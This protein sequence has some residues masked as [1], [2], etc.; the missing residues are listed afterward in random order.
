MFFV[1]FLIGFSADFQVGRDTNFV[2][3]VIASYRIPFSDLVFYKRDTFY[4][5]EY[6]VSLALK[7]DRYQMGGKSKKNKI[8]V[9]DYNETK[10]ENL[11]HSDSIKVEVPEGEVEVILTLSDINSNRVWSKSEKIK[12]SKL[13]SPDIGSIRWLSNPSKEVFT[14]KDTVKIKI[15][16]LSKEKEKIGLTLYFKDEKEKVFFKRDTTFFVNKIQEVKVFIPASKFEEGFYTFFVELKPIERKEV[17]R[18][19]ISFRVWHPFFQSKRF[20]ERV[21]Q[22]EYIATSSEIKKLL[23]AEIEEREKLWNEFWESK[24]PTPGDN[25]NEIQITYFER[26][27]Y[28]NKHFSYNSLFEGWRTDRGKIYIILGPPDYITEEPVSNISEY[29]AYQ[30]WYYYD[31]RYKLIF[32]QRYLTG[33]YELLNPPPEYWR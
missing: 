31:K 3:Y 30:I 4:L 29:Y 16:I 15:N 8:L 24:D 12:I 28:A 11:Y 32:V 2:P 33:D 7:R 18:K 17:I 10:S 1:S 21:R 5:G 23:T 26:V 14:N 22:M 9:N 25:I 19:S 20:L 27:D 6:L 13:K